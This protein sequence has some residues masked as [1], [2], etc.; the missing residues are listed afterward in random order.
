MSIEN[1]MLAR[2]K[3]YMLAAKAREI[4]QREV[5]KGCL[6]DISVHPV[7]LEP[8]YQP[9]FGPRE[10]PD[11]V[12]SGMCTLEVPVPANE[13]VRLRL[14]I[15]PNQKCDWTRSELFLKQLVGVRHR[16][17]FEIIGNHQQ[18]FLQI[19]CH[20]DDQP[21]VRA[22]F[23]GQF[24]QCKLTTAMLSLEFPPRDWSKVSFYDYYPPPPYSHL[25]TSP[26]ELKRSPY[27]TLI[28]A[29]AEI[30]PPGLGFYQVIF[31][32][33]SPEHN[34]HQNVQALLDLEYSIKLLGGISDPLRH[35]QQGPSGDLRNMSTDVQTKAHNDKPF[36][37]AAM[38]IGVID[39]QEQN[40]ATAKA[41]AVI[42]NLFQHGGRPLVFLTDAETLPTKCYRKAPWEDVFLIQPGLP[43]ASQP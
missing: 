41:I 27:A 33:V 18:I 43:D 21:V 17:A 39:D 9:I 42:A 40:N 4:V 24:E 28:T 10:I 31:T 30:P 37:A 11:D 20:Q 29:L 19:L 36:F 34:W 6:P 3:P 22:A 32:P 26:D 23:A 8:I 25:L 12:N 1:A 13:L 14:W 5:C 16:V 7:G 38:R 15:S 35:P 2:A